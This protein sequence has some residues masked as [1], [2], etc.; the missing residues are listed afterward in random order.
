MVRPAPFLNSIF[1]SV[2]ICSCATEKKELRFCDLNQVQVKHSGGLIYVNDSLFTGVLFSLF[3]NSKDTAE[4]YSAVNG[5][6]H[7]TAKQFYPD[8]KPKEIRHFTNG[9]K[10]NEYVGWWPNGKKKLKFNFS[11][12]EYEG[13]CYEWDEQGQLTHEA[14]YHEGHE[15]GAQRAWYSNG[16]IKSNYTMIGGRRYGLL[17]T[18]NCKNV[19]DSVFRKF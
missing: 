14:N 7:G 13:T 6:E 11:N 16:K 19:S 3:T 5:R 8:G 18:K 2:L 17:G 12:D 10:V 15:E 4:I 9:K 1:L